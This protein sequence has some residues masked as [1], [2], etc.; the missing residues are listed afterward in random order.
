MVEKAAV[1]KN[2]AGIHV[3]PSG[4]II[5][6][7]KQYSASISAEA[8]GLSVELNSVMSLL[9]LGLVQGDEVRLR[10]DGKGEEEIA[11]RLVELFEKDYDFPP[12]R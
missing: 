2:S 10:V 6:V 8:N 1:V 4:V 7:V 12:R 3:R 9:S 5:E 11:D